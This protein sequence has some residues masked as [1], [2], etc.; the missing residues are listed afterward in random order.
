VPREKWFEVRM[1]TEDVNEQLE[2][3]AE[4]LKE[5]QRGLRDP[6]FKEQK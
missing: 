1:R 3:M 4:Q 6:Y 5:Q 2:K